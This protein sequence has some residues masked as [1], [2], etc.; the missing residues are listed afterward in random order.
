MSWKIANFADVYF[1]RDRLQSKSREFKC[2]DD[3]E[4]PDFG[5]YV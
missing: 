4:I 5:G 1:F 2:N 3:P